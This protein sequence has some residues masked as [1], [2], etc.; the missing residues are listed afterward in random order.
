MSQRIVEKNLQLVMDALTE[1]EF[2]EFMEEFIKQ[3]G[4][5]SY[6]DY[7]DINAGEV[8]KGAIIWAETKKGFSYWKKISRKYGA[9]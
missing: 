1:E 4:E 8:I 5:Q 9:V 2:Q 6:S 7:I 3:N